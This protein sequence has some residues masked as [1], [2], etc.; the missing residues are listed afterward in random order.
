MYIMCIISQFN[1]ALRIGLSS[2]LIEISFY[3]FV[4]LRCRSQDGG[5]VRNVPEVYVQ[6]CRV[7]I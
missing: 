4:D 5:E 2:V 7:A 6:L 3:L 1:S